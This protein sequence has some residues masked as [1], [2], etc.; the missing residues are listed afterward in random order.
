MNLLQNIIYHIYFLSQFWHQISTKRF[1]S[2]QGQTDIRKDTNFDIQPDTGHR[3]EP[4]RDE[5][6][7]HL[8]S[9]ESSVRNP[10]YDLVVESSDLV[11]I[12]VQPTSWPLPNVRFPAVQF[13]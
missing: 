7:V 13:V 3:L 8:L 2:Y 11:V 4:E 5:Q 9:V 10:I 1:F 12:I 6:I